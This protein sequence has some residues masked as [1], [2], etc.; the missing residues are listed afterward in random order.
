MEDWVK[1]IKNKLLDD[2]IELPLD[3][4][5][6]FEARYLAPKRKWWMIP[7]GG[8]LV[9]AAAAAFVLVII[10]RTAKDNL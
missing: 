1:A 2:Q 6:S 3:D 8:V 4:W 5:E 10:N 9:S 7:L